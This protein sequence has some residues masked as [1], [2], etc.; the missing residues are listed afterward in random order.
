MI[1]K[2]EICGVSFEQDNGYAIGIS[3]QVTGHP[4]V[5]AFNC[6]QETS[7]QHWGCSSEHAVQAAINCLNG[8]MH[9][10]LKNRHREENLKER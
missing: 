9:P 10:H 5:A 1:K 8:H 4:F 6:P 2:C 7:A 3:W